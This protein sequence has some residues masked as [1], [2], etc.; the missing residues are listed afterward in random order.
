MP[1]T[2]TIVYA[3]N[4][5]HAYNNIYLS[6]TTIDVQGTETSFVIHVEYTQVGLRAPK[7]TYELPFTGGVG[8]FPIYLGGIAL[9]GTALYFWRKRRYQKG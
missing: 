6:N 8:L 4:G 9:I 5:A 1:E 7:N 2:R 3:L